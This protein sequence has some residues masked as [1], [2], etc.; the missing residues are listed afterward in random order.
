MKNSKKDVWVALGLAWLA[1]SLYVG[2]LSK[3]YVFEGL[4]RAMPIETGRWAHLFPGNYLLY[5]PLGLLF[6]TLLNSL[7]FHQPAV[8]SLQI[9]DALC[10]AAGVFVFYFLL[11]RLNASVFAGVV[12]SLILACSLGYWLWS[13]DAEDYI[14]STLLLTINFYFLMKYRRKG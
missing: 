10:G 14:L 5:G 11:R 3:A 13:T 6:H 1:F 8:V 4:I 7:G 12:W 2:F 9:M